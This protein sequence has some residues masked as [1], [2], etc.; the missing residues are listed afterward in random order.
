MV[1]ELQFTVSGTALATEIITSSGCSQKQC[2]PFG[3]AI[4]TQATDY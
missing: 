3:L 2:A 1:S 4:L